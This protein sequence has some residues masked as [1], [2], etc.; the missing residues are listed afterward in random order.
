MLNVNVSSLFS[1]LIVLAWDNDLFDI[2]AINA[3]I[4]LPNGFAQK[5]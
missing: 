5:A 1:Q 2:V 4:G 3:S